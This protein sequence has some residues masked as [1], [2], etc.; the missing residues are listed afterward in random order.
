[1]FNVHCSTTYIS[2][3]IKKN[4]ISIVGIYLQKALAI[5]TFAMI[6]MNGMTMIPVP[7]SALMSM[8]VNVLLPF[9]TENAGK[10]TFGHPEG[11]FAKN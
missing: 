1:M 2:Y 10:D 8:K 9:S 7:N 3:I 4:G 11:T 6:A 5:P